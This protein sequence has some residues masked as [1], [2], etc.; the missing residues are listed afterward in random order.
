MTDR[1][2]T[3]LALRRFQQTAL[4]MH[5]KDNRNAKVEPANYKFQ[6]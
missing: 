2:I 4:Y 5:G 3:A 6:I 1:Q